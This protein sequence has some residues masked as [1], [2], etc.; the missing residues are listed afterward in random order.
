MEDIK[1]GKNAAGSYLGFQFLLVFSILIDFPKKLRER[2]VAN[3]W[4]F[5]ELDGAPR[6]L[7]FSRAIKE[8]TSADLTGS[9]TA[10]G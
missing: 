3:T 2:L 6:G 5:D 4:N 1:S 8:S 10:L 9:M 7:Y